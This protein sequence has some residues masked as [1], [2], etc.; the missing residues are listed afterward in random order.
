VIKAGADLNHSIAVVGWGVDSETKIAYWIGRN[1]WGTY[2]GEHGF[3]KM[4]MNGNNLL[5]ET[6]CTAGIPTLT[7]ATSAS[8]NETEII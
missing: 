8:K 1:S 2:W 7:K 3:F 6:E 5:I 4:I